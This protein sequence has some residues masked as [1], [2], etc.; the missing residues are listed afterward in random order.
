MYVFSLFSKKCTNSANYFFPKKIPVFRYNPI[1]REQFDD[2]VLT[3][4]YFPEMSRSPVISQ[5][6]PASPSSS[7]R[8]DATSESH[9][10]A[11]MFM[12][13]AIGTL[14]DPAATPYNLEAEKFHQLA[15]VALFQGST[16]DDPTLNAVQAVVSNNVIKFLE[17]FLVRGEFCTQRVHF[18]C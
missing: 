11:L 3:P 7:E 13:L 15:R 14:M 16:F 18:F 12:V 2:Q 9:R 1:T 17:F 4:I 8:D 6:L 5:Y 10:L